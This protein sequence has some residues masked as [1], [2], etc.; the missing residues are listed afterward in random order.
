MRVGVMG[1]FVMAA[2]NVYRY[3]LMSMARRRQR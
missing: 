3:R 2:R 1:H